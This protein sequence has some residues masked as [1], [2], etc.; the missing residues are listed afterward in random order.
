MDPESVALRLQHHVKT[1]NFRSL[2][3]QMHHCGTFITQQPLYTLQLLEK[4]YL[5]SVS[6]NIFRHVDTSEFDLLKF[7]TKN[8]NGEERGFQ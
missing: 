4:H 2:L 7:L 3:K 5:Y 1:L 6:G 8:Q